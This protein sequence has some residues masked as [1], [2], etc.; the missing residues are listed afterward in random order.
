MADD[1]T[2]PK[3]VI[4]RA[5]ARRLVDTALDHAR[6]LGKHVSI[7]VVDDGGFLIAFGRDDEANPSSVQIA[8]DKAY[9]AAVTRIATH[10]WQ[11]TVEEDLPLRY[12]AAVGVERLITFG[13]GQPIVIGGTVV[14]GIGSSGAHWTGDTEITSAA[15]R[16][17]EA[18]GTE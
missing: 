12:G 6:E 15:L 4:T 3:A 18:E 16:S 13:G 14:G 5:A 9:T 1:L 2:R 8:I 17:L 10:Q 11:K 7:A